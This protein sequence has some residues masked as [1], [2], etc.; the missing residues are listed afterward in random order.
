MEISSVS[1]QHDALDALN[2]GIA[3][4]KVNWVLDL[5]IRAFF[6]RTTSV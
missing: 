4:K 5:D 1:S 6:D 2:V 3:R